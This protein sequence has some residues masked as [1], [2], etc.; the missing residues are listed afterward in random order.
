MCNRYEKY[1]KSLNIKFSLALCTNNKQLQQTCEAIL[2]QA[3]RNMYSKIVKVVNIK[4]HKLWQQ[5]RIKIP[6]TCSQRNNI[7]L[8]QISDGEFK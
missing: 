5:C 6:E 8:G 1:P 4:L 2:N 7:E 3:S